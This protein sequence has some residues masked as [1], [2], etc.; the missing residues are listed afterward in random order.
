M[1]DERTGVDRVLDWIVPIRLSGKRMSVEVERGVKI[2]LS[3]IL[4]ATIPYPRRHQ[5]NRN[6]RSNRNCSRNSAYVCARRRTGSLSIRQN[7]GSEPVFFPH[8]ALRYNANQGIGAKSDRRHPNNKR[9]R[10]CT[11]FQYLPLKCRSCLQR[12]VRSA[13]A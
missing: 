13:P 11:I 2:M 1:S 9:P 5:R 4:L 7:I 6:T 8:R 10:N 12:S 3:L